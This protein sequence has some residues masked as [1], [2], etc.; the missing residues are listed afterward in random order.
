MWITVGIEGRIVFP[1]PL[2]HA[3]PVGFPGRV[4]ASIPLG[5]RWREPSQAHFRG[6][7][8]S[9]LQCKPDRVVETVLS[10]LLALWVESDP[11]VIAEV[12]SRLRSVRTAQPVGDDPDGFGS[13]VG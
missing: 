2:A 3:G 5:G 7:D 6:W 11:V 8:F 13:K 1:T 9:R 10:E 4:P 12:Q